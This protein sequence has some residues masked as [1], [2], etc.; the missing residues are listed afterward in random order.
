MNPTTYMYN[1]CGY[2]MTNGI[3]VG[4]IMYGMGACLVGIVLMHFAL[5]RQ[6]L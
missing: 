1:I 5:K 4:T 2:R 3:V 6:E